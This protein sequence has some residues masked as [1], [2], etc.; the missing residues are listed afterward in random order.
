MCS[1]WDLPLLLQRRLCAWVQHVAGA[2]SQVVSAAG[3]GGMVTQGPPPP[4]Q[5]LGVG[6]SCAQA[7]GWHL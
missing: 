7:L 4:R 5:Q 3:A 2:A 6:S 1:A